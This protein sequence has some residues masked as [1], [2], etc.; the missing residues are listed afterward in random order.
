MPGSILEEDAGNDQVSH[1]HPN[2]IQTTSEKIKRTQ[3]DFIIMHRMISF[4]ILIRSKLM[5]S[6]FSKTIRAPEP[7]ASPETPFTQELQMTQEG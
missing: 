5:V 6:K 3:N 1:V 2:L 4:K 7:D